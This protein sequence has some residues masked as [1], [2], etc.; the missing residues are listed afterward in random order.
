MKI[1]T[2]VSSELISNLE[3]N[4]EEDDDCTLKELQEG[5]N[6][7]YESHE[8]LK[9][10]SE[11]LKEINKNLKT[12]NCTLTNEYISFEKQKSSDENVN[13]YVEIL[14]LKIKMDDLSKQLKKISIILLK[15]TKDYIHR[16]IETSIEI[17][18]LK[19]EI[20]K[21]NEHEVNSSIKEKLEILTRDELKSTVLQFTKNKENTILIISGTN[22]YSIIDMFQNIRLQIINF[23]FQK[24]VYKT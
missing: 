14:Y 20:L 2:K 22:Y 15:V 19:A 18:E 24:S 21:L 12:E 5:Y 16:N 6:D 4:I 17:N 11:K 1:W 9:E 10:E 8:K 13:L 7:L 23:L 3:T